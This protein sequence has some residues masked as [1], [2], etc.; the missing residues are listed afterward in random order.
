MTFDFYNCIVFIS[1]TVVSEPD[2][3]T[4]C[5]EKSS[6]PLTCVLNGNMTS[7]DVQWYRL[8]KDTSTEQR[9]GTQ[10][11]GFTVVLHPGMG[12]FTT[13]L[14]IANARESYTGY[15]WVRSPLGDVCNTYFTVLTGILYVV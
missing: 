6:P 12:N 11:E 15:Y 10:L 1:T 3:V 9:I 4:V 13:T 7:N 2:N 14:N 8:L 5:E